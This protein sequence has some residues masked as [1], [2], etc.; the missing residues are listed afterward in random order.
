MLEKGLSQPAMSQDQS[1]GKLNY[2][3]VYRQYYNGDV[4]M[5]VIRIVMSLPSEISVHFDNTSAKV[6]QLKTGS[7][8]T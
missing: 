2:C 5:G 8:I 7:S 6:N 4:T 1:L 3:Y